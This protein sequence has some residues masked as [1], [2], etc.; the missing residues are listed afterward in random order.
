V[1]HRYQIPVVARGVGTGLCAG[2]MPNDDGVVLSLA[3]FKYI[4]EIEPLARTARL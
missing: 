3:K 2:A 1:C 4:L